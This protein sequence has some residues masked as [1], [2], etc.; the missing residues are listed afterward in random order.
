MRWQRPALAVIC[1]ARSTARRAI[2]PAGAGGFVRTE[3]HFD[4]D[5]LVPDLAGWR[6]SRMPQLTD[7]PYFTLA[8][9]W[10]CEVV[11]PSTG[12]LDRVRKMRVYGREQVAHAWLVDP[13]QKTLEVY[14]LDGDRWV[15]AGTYGGDECVCAEPF[16][17]VELQ[18]TR[19]WLEG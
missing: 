5:V 11:S 6:R 4:A 8:P 18:L 14:R 16:E 12:R 13:L 9:D 2:R 17:A 1:S 19:W 10:I 7:V 15:V 3:L